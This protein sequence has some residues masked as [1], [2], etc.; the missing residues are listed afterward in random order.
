MSELFSILHC[1]FSAHTAFIS[2]ST[3]CAPD[4]LSPLLLS[5]LEVPSV[6][7]TF[8][9]HLSVKSFHMLLMRSLPRVSSHLFNSNQLSTFSRRT[10]SSP[11]KTRKISSYIGTHDGT[12]HCDDVTAC[13]ML[14]QMKR[15]KN[16]DIVR[17]RNPEKLAEAEIIVDVGGELDLEKLRLDHHQRSFNQTI[18]DFHPSMKTTN[19]DKPVR[20]SSSGLVYAVFGKDII[21]ELLQL[22]NN[23][24][25]L[26]DEHKKMVDS[27]H[28]KAY[29]EL[30]EE[31]DAIDNGVEIVSND[32]AVY[33]YHI[34]SGISSRV[35]RLNPIESSA[36]PEERLER[37]KKAMEM[38]GNEL[39]EALQFLGKVW[40]P[41]RQALLELFMKRK[42]FDPS[43]Q[44]VLIGSGSLNGWKS[45]FFDFE[46]ELNLQGQ[47]KFVIY[48]DASEKAQWRVVAMPVSLKSFVCRLPLK[49]EWRGKRDEDLQEC[50]GVSDA[51]FV[52][53]S[54]FTGGAKSLAGVKSL[55]D[56][57]LNP[58]STD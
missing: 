50:S 1:N 26:D 17:T 10:M 32:N 43:G 25:E 7:L 52:H 3:A 38:V 31:I 55:I 33:N 42:D 58:S 14:K 18:R 20:L 35:A 29:V 36:T 39:T 48:Q 56:K 30:F 2:V 34:S 46:E 23:Y 22:G 49:E 11:N 8:L 9:E 15:F 19:P 28:S 21:V 57:T 51:T 41:S 24:E 44:V 47:I 27:I 40:W 13:F 5:I 54:G 4:S 12:F 6:N 16:H 37:F 53:M 45:A